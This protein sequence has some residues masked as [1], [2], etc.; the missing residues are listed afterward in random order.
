VNPRAIASV[1]VVATC[2]AASASAQPTPQG[3]RVP[4]VTRLVKVFTELENALLEQAREPDS[5]ALERSLDPSF[6]S[7]AGAA[8]GTPVPRDQWIRQARAA[9][10]TGV[11]IEQ[12]A[13]HDYGDIA[14][15]SFR[16]IEPGARASAPPRER[17]IVDCWTRAGNGWKLAVRYASCAAPSAAKSLPPK[18]FDKRY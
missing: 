17:F 13:V 2:V 16:E 10:R 12:M 3:S 4:T 8:P 1:L 9:A 6:E 5:A 18:T 14:L 15:V 11:R 7:R